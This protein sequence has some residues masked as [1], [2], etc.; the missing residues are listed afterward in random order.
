MNT[1]KFL[2][3]K[4]SCCFCLLV[5]NQGAI[6]V[7]T[8]RTFQSSLRIT[9]FPRFCL[10]ILW[11]DDLYTLRLHPK[12]AIFKL[13]K[14]FKCQCC[15]PSNVMESC[16]EHFMCFRSSLTENTMLMHCSCTL[17]RARAPPPTHAHARTQHT[18]TH[19]TTQHT[20]THTH[21]LEVIPPPANL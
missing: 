2:A 5:S 6:S 14:P 12:F 10:C 4:N 18:H 1:A 9:S 16:F 15:L 20:H 17:A 11:S 19:N 13:T 21:T 8:H 3:V 7:E